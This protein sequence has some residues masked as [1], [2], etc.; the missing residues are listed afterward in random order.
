MDFRECTR[1]LT[2]LKLTGMHSF[3][4]APSLTMVNHLGSSFLGEGQEF[5]LECKYYVI[6]GVFP[7]S[8]RRFSSTELEGCV[9]GY[10][11]AIFQSC[12]SV[13]EGNIKFQIFIQRVVEMFKVPDLFSGVD[14]LMLQRQE[15]GGG[16]TSISQPTIPVQVVLTHSQHSTPVAESSKAASKRRAV[17]PPPSPPP[18]KSKLVRPGDGWYVVHTGVLPGVYYGA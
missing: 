8:L 16:T 15:G 4:M 12:A 7:L 11:N 10:E 17:D 5:L 6:P 18:Q 2:P 14:T 3:G 1:L 13:A 9:R